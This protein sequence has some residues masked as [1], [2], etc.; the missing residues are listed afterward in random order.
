MNPTNF[1][2]DLIRKKPTYSQGLK[3]YFKKST[4]IELWKRKIYYKNK[5]SNL[6]SKCWSKMRRDVKIKTTLNYT[7]VSYVIIAAIVVLLNAIATGK[8]DWHKQFKKKNNT[9][10]KTTTENKTKQRKSWFSAFQWFGVFVCVCVCK[11][12]KSI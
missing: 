5:H 7:N 10:T 6:S 1:L 12:V 3:R 8:Q 11:Y 2:F 4:K 9:E